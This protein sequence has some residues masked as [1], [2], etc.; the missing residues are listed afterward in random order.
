MWHKIVSEVDCPAEVVHF[1]L[2]SE[3]G[4]RR[5]RIKIT[6]LT[7]FRAQEEK[8]LV[9]VKLQRPWW[10]E[11]ICFTFLPSLHF[12]NEIVYR[13]YI[14][15]IYFYTYFSIIYYTYF[16]CIIY[17]IFQCVLTPQWL[18]GAGTLSCSVQHANTNANARQS[19]AVLGVQ[20]THTSKPKTTNGKVIFFSKKINIAKSTPEILIVASN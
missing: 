5:F 13:I 7:D 3:L 2:V 12:I 19:A 8:T 14:I 17:C 20:Y 16:K 6:N 9:L 18:P 4:D 10:A 15:F 11:L 1:D